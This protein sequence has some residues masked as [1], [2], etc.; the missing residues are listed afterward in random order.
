MTP[1]LLVDLVQFSFSVIWLQEL[2][3][4]DDTVTLLHN[5][6]IDGVKLMAL[7]ILE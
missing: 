4:D 6:T 7:K 2:V 3:N 1:K 5:T